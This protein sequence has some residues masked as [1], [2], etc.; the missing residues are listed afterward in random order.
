MP[1]CLSILSGISG[2]VVVHQE[3]STKNRNGPKASFSSLGAYS[4]K[5]DDDMKSTATA[6]A[7]ELTEDQVGDIIVHPRGRLHIF[8][9][10]FHVI[11]FV[12]VVVR[13]RG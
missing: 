7:A 1:L 6:S 13:L 8:F 9:D 10:L 11:S 2:F 3:S 12:V 4:S 5:T